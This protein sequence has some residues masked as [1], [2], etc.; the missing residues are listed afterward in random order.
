MS[1]LTRRGA[2]CDIIVFYHYINCNIFYE[3]DE[4]EEEIGV[5]KKKPPFEKLS[6]SNS[7]KDQ[8]YQRMIE[9][10][11]R[12]SIICYGNSLGA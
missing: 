2:N 1:L 8:L 6:L 10:R 4:S 9:E 11:V 5:V 12:N 3:S 7:T